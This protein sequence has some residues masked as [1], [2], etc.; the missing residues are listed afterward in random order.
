[1][2]EDAE[3]GPKIEKVDYK[4]QVF[5]LRTQLLEIQNELRKERIPVLII[6]GGVDGA[7]KGESLNLLNEWMDPRYIEARAFRWDLSEEERERP[8]YWRFWR[9]L[10]PK[11]K[12]GI[13]VGS[14]HSK[15]VLKSAYGLWNDDDLNDSIG[16][17][18]TL[19]K[20]LADDGML[21]IK[22]WFHLSKKAQKT[23]LKKL[24]KDAST[25]W[26][27][28]ETD[29]K[30]FLMYDRFTDVCWKLVQGTSTEQVPWH[31]INGEN[32]RFRNLTVGRIVLDRISAHIKQKH[33]A[34]S[35]VDKKP[36]RVLKIKS[37]NVLKKLDLSQ[38]V[39]EEEARAELE[40]QQGNLNIL[41]RKAKEKAHSTILVFEGCDAAGKGGVIRRVTAALDARDYTIIPIAAPTD[42]EKA[43]HYLWRF[44]RHIPRA[45][46]I[47]IF[48]RSWYGRVLVERVEGFAK[49]EEWARAYAEINDF[50]HQLVEHG[51]SLLKFWMHIDKDEQLRRFEERQNTPFKQFKI[52]EEDWRNREKWDD[53]EVAVNDMVKLTSTDFAPWHLI[54][55]N[56]KQYARIKVLQTICDKL[57]ENLT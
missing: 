47:T 49:P 35:G 43:H 3:I 20:E 18:Q 1:M 45:G 38:K 55:A 13:F 15:P 51:V 14:W 54:P 12:I 30:H 53:Y 24:D 8:E 40:I 48:D 19:E 7:G 22:F 46:R 21:I 10:P 25:R 56:D 36:T 34:A 39:S 52:T 23:R 5:A 29:W 2:F 27:V 9:V 6:I 37:P 16:R 28:T 4:A 33:D 42:E 44:W 17:I 41:Y 32:D 11:G 57:K 50:E 26:R 31:I